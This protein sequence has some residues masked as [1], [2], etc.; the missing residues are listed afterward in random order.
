LQNLIKENNPMTPELIASTAGII[1]SLFFSYVPKASDW[2]VGLDGTRKRLVMLGILLVVALSVFGLT[3]A[4]LTQ[5]SVSCD[6][7]GAI[8]IINAFIAAVIANQSTY[9][10]TPKTAK[11]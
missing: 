10:L 9:M 6:R 4:G 7:A 11:V 2:Y 1:L 8:Q 3:C 5:Y